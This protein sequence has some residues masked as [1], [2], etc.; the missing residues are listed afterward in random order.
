VVHFALLD[1][2]SEYGSGSTGLIESGSNTDPDPIPCSRLSL[3]CLQNSEKKSA[4]AEQIEAESEGSPV[5]KPRGRRGPKAGVQ[6]K[7]I[8]VQVRY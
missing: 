6:E 4:R 5:L 3:L 8:S 2:D 1:P 7:T